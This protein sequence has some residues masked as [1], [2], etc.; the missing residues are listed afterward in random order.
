MAIKINLNT[1]ILFF[2][3]IFAVLNVMSGCSNNAIDIVK[4]GTLSIDKST[5]VGNALENYVYFSKITWNSFEDSQ[6]RRIVEFVGYLNIEKII[7]EKY[8]DRNDCDDMNKYLLSL[9]KS[10]KIDFSRLAFVKILFFIN[11]DMHGFTVGSSA[12]IF[13]NKDAYCPLNII[14]TIYV[15]E[16]LK[17]VLDSLDSK[18]IDYQKNNLNSRFN[19]NYSNFIEAK[20]NDILGLYSEIKHIPNVACVPEV[21]I[22]YITQNKANID[23]VIKGTAC[24]GVPLVK[25]ENIDIKINP[26]MDISSNSKNGIRIEGLGQFS[27][28]HPKRNYTLKYDIKFILFQKLDSKFMI[29]HIG[30][31]DMYQGDLGHVME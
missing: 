7:K 14:K 21:N 9:A 3:L 4:N 15:N 16:V 19:T 10:N 12:I 31:G 20:K 11:A 6:K 18:Y 29:M 5:T 2:I 17:C 30:I 23:V 28:K 13:A 24:F 26:V 1:R 22:N 25:F 8:A 27:Y